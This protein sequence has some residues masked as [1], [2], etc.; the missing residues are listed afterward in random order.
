MK[1][2]LTSEN[3]TDRDANVKFFRNQIKY[4]PKGD[5]LENILRDYWG[6]YDL[7]QSNTNYTQWLFPLRTKGFNS[8][9]QILQL[10][11]L[12][13]LK[14]DERAIR[15]L[16]KSYEMMLNFYGMKFKSNSRIEIIR[17]DN[18]KERYRNRIE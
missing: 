14:K 18:Y 16:L 2:K 3:I 12:D 17:A 13:T 6:D 1:I 8:Y 11:E 15:L 10:H 9:S 5:Y 7:L 4:E